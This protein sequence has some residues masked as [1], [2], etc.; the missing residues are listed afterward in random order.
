[1]GANNHARQSN[2]ELLR[3]LTMIAIVAHHFAVHGGF[4]YA[5]ESI[6]LNR[7]WIQFLQVGGKIGVNVFILIS[8]YFLISLEKAKIGKILKLWSQV[9]FYSIVLFVIF[10]VT[11]EKSFDV[12]SLIYHLLPITFRQWWFASSYFVLFLLV[13]YINTLLKS[14]NKRQYK[15]F[16]LLL[17]ICWCI[18]PTLTYT[19]FEGNALLWFV[20]LYSVSGYIRLFGFKTNLSGLKLVAISLAGILLI[21]VSAIVFDILG[22]KI[23]LFA[24]NTTYFYGM[25]RIPTFVVALLLFVGFLNIQIKTSKVINT[26]SAAMFG[27]YLIHDNEDVRVFIWNTLFNSSSYSENSMLI[28]YSLLIILVV[29]I[30]CTMIELLRIHLLEKNYLPIIN[31]LAQVIDKKKETVLSKLER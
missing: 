17:F 15:G 28:L 29:F 24:D 31:K 21:F 12:R 9:F 16:L 2:I 25:N 19:S 11:K 26:I 23:A 20:F 30:C 5:T 10:A 22:T 13:P 6:S 8:G 1:M 3:I 7:F 18:I 27:V 4:E 14:F